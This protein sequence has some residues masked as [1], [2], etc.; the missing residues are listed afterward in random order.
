M[1]CTIFVIVVVHM[2]VVVHVNMAVDGFSFGLVVAFQCKLV[3]V[4]RLLVTAYGPLS[5]RGE[6]LGVKLVNVLAWLKWPPFIQYPLKARAQNQI[7]RELL[8]RK[9]LQNRLFRILH[10]INCL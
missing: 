4:I 10:Q 9:H 8:V 6:S 1:L 7:V 5:L 3:V 2:A